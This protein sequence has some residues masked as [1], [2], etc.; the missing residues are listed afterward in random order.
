MGSRYLL[1]N[2][3]HLRL[4]S[5][6]EIEG[7]YVSVLWQG[8]F[9]FSNTFSTRAAEQHSIVLNHNLV[10]PL[11]DPPTLT[12]L[13]QSWEKH[14]I[15]FQHEVDLNELRTRPATRKKLEVRQGEI[16]EFTVHLL[17][18]EEFQIAPDFRT[19]VAQHFL[20][21]HSMTLHDEDKTPDR[22]PSFLA[23]RHEAGEII[24]PVVNAVAMIALPSRLRFQ[25]FKNGRLRATSREYSCEEL[26]EGTA[27]RMV[28]GEDVGYDLEV[29]IFW[30][31]NL[32]R[33]RADRAMLLDAQ[34]LLLYEIEARLETGKEMVG[35]KLK[36][37]CGTR[38]FELGGNFDSAGTTQRFPR[39]I[40]LVM[41]SE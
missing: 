29:N 12:L 38:S 3:S 6:R 33:H 26:A 7:D 9:Y 32:W 41:K 17:E 23:V 24:V 40:Y 10:L 14:M 20:L 8:R 39:I 21:I 13:L 27:V 15:V 11:P 4:R 36:V 2:L 19:D 35:A 1:V 5:A 34:E 31:I 25:H 18:P 37:V 22:G 16:L 30:G 28:A